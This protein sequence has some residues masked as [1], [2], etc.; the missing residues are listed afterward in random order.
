MRSAA[1]T[2]ESARCS[3]TSH[4]KVRSTVHVGPPNSFPALLTRPGQYVWFLSP[5][6]HYVH[7]AISMGV[8]IYLAADGRWHLAEQR[9]GRE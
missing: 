2:R 4:R 6:S 3:A 7:R 5:S 1:E 9:A 8:I